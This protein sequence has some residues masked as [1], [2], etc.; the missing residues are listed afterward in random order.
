M[1]G[2]AIK[3]SF[4][5]RLDAWAR[6]MTP[7]ALT[8]LLALISVLPVQIPGFAVVGP[9]LV[10][11]AVYYWAIYRPEVLPFALVFLLGLF[12]DTLTGSPL[13]LSALIYMLAYGLVAGQRRFFLGKSFGV[14]WWGFMLVA[15]AAESLR[16]LLVSI[17]FGVPVSPTPGM[18]AYLMTVAF[19]PLGTLAMAAVHRILPQ[20]A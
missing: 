7:A 19:Y 14:V 2:L 17:Y 18:F 9:G 4:L 16:W 1:Q 8:L 10:L 13:G 11:M 20:R 12:H 3:Q 15:A 6:Y 5:Q